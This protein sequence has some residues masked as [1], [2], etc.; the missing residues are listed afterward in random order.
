MVL[1]MANADII[2]EIFEFSKKIQTAG[3]VVEKI[4]EIVTFFQSKKVSAELLLF[5]IHNYDP[6]TST[7]LDFAME[8]CR[9]SMEKKNVSLHP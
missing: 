6:S 8:G 9:L 7:W 3:S 1:N 2:D 4:E 5:A